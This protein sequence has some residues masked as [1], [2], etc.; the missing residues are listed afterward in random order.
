MNFP[1]VTFPLSPKCLSIAQFLSIIRYSVKSGKYCFI[2]TLKESQFVV[3]CWQD[4]PEGLSKFERRTSVKIWFGWNNVGYILLQGYYTVSYTHKKSL[5]RERLWYQTLPLKSFSH[6][7]GIMV[8][9][10][11]TYAMMQLR[12]HVSRRIMIILKVKSL[13]H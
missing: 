7:L 9:E 4:F 1:F 5:F 10:T 12:S 8:C 2:Y 13:I 11:D 6:V 3:H